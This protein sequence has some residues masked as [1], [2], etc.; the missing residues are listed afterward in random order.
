MSSA[1]GCAQ[2]AHEHW[3][4]Y[5]SYLQNLAETDIRQRGEQFAEICKGWAFG[6]AD[7]KAELKARLPLSNRADARLE[8]V[9]ADREA[10]REVR[11][12]IWEDKLQLAAAALHLSLANLP[13]AKSAANKVQLAALLKKTTSVSNLWLARRLHMGQASSVSQFVGRFR[14]AGGTETGEFKSALSRV[15]T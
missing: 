3:R 8:I 13:A 2:F 9:G 1:N 15:A 7:F 12:A 4:Y 10:H 11:A 6:S 14:R 5:V